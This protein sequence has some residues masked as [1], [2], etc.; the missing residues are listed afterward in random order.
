[1]NA[2]DNLPSSLTTASFEFFKIGHQT[3]QLHAGTVSEID[4][5][6]ADLCNQISKVLESDNLA[7]IGF[8]RLN[9]QDHQEKVN[10]FF[11]CNYSAFDSE[12]DVSD[13]GLI[14]GFEF[15]DCKNRGNCLAEGFICKFPF[16][17]T[18]KQVE[19]AQRIALGQQDNQICYELDITQNTLRKHKNSIEL[20]IGEYGKPAIA[21]FAVRKKLI[22]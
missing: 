14:G 17:L 10:K 7:K 5:I 9:I 2:V 12:S 1:M 18:K 4:S 21:A 6:P 3:M 16:Q 13:E 11:D 8:N 15:I 22:R 20:K 19:V